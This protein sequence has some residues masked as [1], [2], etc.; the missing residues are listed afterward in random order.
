MGGA[1]VLHGEVLYR[2]RL[3]VLPF[4]YPPFAAVV[5][6]AL[7]AVPFG[8]AV[9]LLTGASV[10]LLTG[11]S[12]AALPVTLYLALRLSRSGEPGPPG[13]GSAPVVALAAAAAAIWLIP[14]GPRSATARWT[15][16]WPRWCCTT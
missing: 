2:L 10:V 3:G 11:A 15:F 7:A 12:V 16:S 13:G 9:V 14:P 1:A 8:A 6:T 5:L 4:T